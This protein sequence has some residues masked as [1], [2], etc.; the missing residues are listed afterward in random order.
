MLND[1]RTLKYKIINATEIKILPQN[2]ILQLEM[3]M[4]DVDRLLTIDAD[5]DRTTKFIFDDT[6][7]E[8]I[9]V[10]IWYNNMSINVVFRNNKAILFQFPT[11]TRL[12]LNDINITNK[13]YKDTLAF[14]KKDGLKIRETNDD[15]SIIDELNL[16]L[17]HPYE[18][19]LE[20]ASIYKPGIYLSEEQKAKYAVSF[21][22]ENG[23]DVVKY[24]IKKHA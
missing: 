17:Y 8:Y 9:D 24:T 14:L 22:R 6:H 7:D 18:N 13:N 15:E 5:S 2:D 3:S 16:I 10:S 20:T 19:E 12:I 23:Y 4:Q 1:M 11:D 21:Y